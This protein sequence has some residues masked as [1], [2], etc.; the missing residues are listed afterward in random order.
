M[1]GV[2]KQFD[3]NLADWAKRAERELRYWML[4]HGYEYTHHPSGI[5]GRDGLCV[6]NGEKFYV[7]VERCSAKRWAADEPFPFPTLHILERRGKNG[8]DG[9]LLFVAREDVQRGFIAFPRTSIKPG[10]LIRNPNKYVKSGEEWVYDVPLDEV[11]P[12]DYTI[13]EGEPIGALNAKRIRAIVEKS[14]SRGFAA[15]G[16]VPPYG[17]SDK[18]WRELLDECEKPLKAAAFCP[19]KDM[20]KVKRY[21]EWCER[22]AE[23]CEKCGRFYGCVREE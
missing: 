17:I 2:E 4:G 1:R 13:V 15:L 8:I 7:E 20:P 5:Y 14:R 16:D 11:L 3:Q 18:E 10:R 22:M 12:V 23:W 6:G 9:W 19:C 21:S